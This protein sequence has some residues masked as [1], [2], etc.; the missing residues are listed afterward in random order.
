M[1]V[2]LKWNCYLEVR[3]GFGEW[4]RKTNAKRARAGSTGRT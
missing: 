1:Y 2:P 4:A 3:F